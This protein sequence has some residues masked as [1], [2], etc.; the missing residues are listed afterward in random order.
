MT[1]MSTLEKHEQAR[2]AAPVAH[3]MEST[4]TIR[5]IG[6]ACV[7]AVVAHGIACASDAPIVS[8]VAM[9]Q[10]DNRLVTISYM[11]TGAPGIV[12]LDIETNAVVNG[13]STWTSIGGSNVTHVTG[14]ACKLVQNSASETR[15]IYWAPDKSWPD[16]RIVSPDKIRA[17][18]KAVSTNTP[19]DYMVCNLIDGTRFYYDTAEQLPG[20]IDSDDYRKHLFVMRKIHAKGKTFRMCTAKSQ[21][22]YMSLYDTP[23]LVGFT[24]DYYMGVFEVTQWQWRYAM[25]KISG[26]AAA[27]LDPSY[28]KGDLLP[29]E[30]FI[31]PDSN[32][33]GSLPGP[34]KTEG[35]EYI[36]NWSLGNNNTFVGKMR[37]LTGL[38][39]KLHSPTEAQW[40]FACRAGTSTA[41][42]DG[43][44]YVN[45]E[46]TM[47][48]TLSKIAR[49]AY[50]AYTD[51]GDGTI[52]TNGTARVGSY[53]PNPW[54]L[55]DMHGN[56]A[57]WCRDYRGWEI[58]GLYT[59]QTKVY[60]DPTGPA[61][62]DDT[63]NKTC[64]TTHFTFRGGG[65]MDSSKPCQ[66]GY[67]GGSGNCWGNDLKRQKIGCRLCFTIFDE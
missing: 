23:H 56:V 51:N 7:M 41:Y 66:S 19:P 62:V 35:G 3:A 60:V 59:D 5:R 61:K 57:E 6:L 43:T 22:G 14:D 18:V 4:M 42:S 13:V 27:K 9:V 24:H 15:K 20:G 38:G 31:P 55:Y 36:D 10:A 49:Y 28:F 12:T 54:G 25:S 44:E 63:N 64:V 29:V 26:V 58:M 40:E 47:A 34:T 53:A 17:V 1:A 67:R 32:L 2:V 30:R 21:A 33:W 46:E 37:T 48:T 11:L 16:H 39:E 52:T 45:N 50:N 65:W 8:D